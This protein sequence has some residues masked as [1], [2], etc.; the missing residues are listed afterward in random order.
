M[1]FWNVVLGMERQE[2][3]SE[4]FNPWGRKV[5]KM[6]RLVGQKFHEHKCA[7]EPEWSAANAAAKAG[8][9][10][11]EAHG[12]PGTSNASKAGTHVVI[13]PPTYYFPEPRIRNPF[14]ILL[15]DSK[16]LPFASRALLDVILSF[17][18]LFHF[19]L[20]TAI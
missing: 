7:V 5:W 19:R 17:L 9:S 15:Y 20:T 8:Q 16:S 3:L 4:D 14:F 12:T 11:K 2:Q 1:V 13:A 6:K 10:S 18:T